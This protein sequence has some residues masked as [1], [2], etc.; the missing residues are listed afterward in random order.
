MSRTRDSIS[1]GRGEAIP[2]DIIETPAR[3]ET[4]LE[5]EDTLLRMLVVLEN[6]SQSGVTGGSAPVVPA[7]A[8]GAQIALESEDT[9]EFLTLCDEMLE[10]VG[11]LDAHGVRFIALQLCGLTKEW[12]K[13]FVRSRPVGSPPDRVG[14]DLWCFPVPLHPLERER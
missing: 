8:I 2:E 9:H 3:V 6:F 1:T 13:T 7:P 4:G 11:M 10:E 14:H 12:W 5:I